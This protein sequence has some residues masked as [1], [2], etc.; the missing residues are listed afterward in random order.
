MP[1]DYRNPTACVAVLIVRSGE[2]LL[3]RRGVEPMKGA[4]DT[5]GGFV[6]EHES[7][8]EALVRETREETGLEVGK[9]DYLGSVHDHYGLE[10]KPI[11]H[12]CFLASV[13]DGNPVA[14][15]DV[16]SLAWFPLDELP[17]HMAFPNQSKVLGFLKARLAG[18]GPSSK[19][20]DAK[21]SEQVEACRRS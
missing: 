21:R 18:A 15:S 1:L 5:V 2:L 8:E 10:Q 20:V 4:W 19:V 14:R 3:A 6:D 12:L 7:A 13:V 11:L 16:A 17:D 9:I